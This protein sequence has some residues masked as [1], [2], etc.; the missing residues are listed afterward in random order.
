[1]MHH[2]VP[3][4]LLLPCIPLSIN[5]VN[6]CRD[7]RAVGMPRKDIYIDLKED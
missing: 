6:I 4:I 7:N 1:M 5:K 3:I 2:I